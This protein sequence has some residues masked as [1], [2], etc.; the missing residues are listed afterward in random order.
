MALYDNKWWLLS[1]IQHSFVLSDDTGN[2]ELVMT[3]RDAAF[4]AERSAARAREEG[5]E[6]FLGPLRDCCAA[7]GEAA[8]ADGEAGGG[9]EHFR[10]GSFDIRLGR[11]QLLGFRRARSNT[12]IKLEKMRRD[13]RA[14]ETGGAT[15]GRTIN[16]REIDQAAAVAATAAAAHNRR[17]RTLTKEELDE[18]F[19]VAER[20]TDEE[21]EEEDEER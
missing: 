9:G 4:C 14:A 11:N 3:G 7:Q 20:S 1:H 12:E 2:S 8:A 10:A 15:K 16:W 19:P 5:T 13:R 17:R 6:H 18:F 21:E